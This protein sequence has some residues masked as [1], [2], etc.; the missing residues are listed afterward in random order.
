MATPDPVTIIGDHLRS[1]PEIEAMVG[2]RVQLTLEGTYP[3]IRL[4]LVTGDQAA[5]VA[6]PGEYDPEFQVECWADKEQ[7]AVTLARL[8]RD[9]LSDGSINGERSGAWVAGAAVTAEPFTAFDPTSSRPRYI[10][11]TTL[12]IFAL[13]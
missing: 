3:A 11:Q 7:D 4:T 12:V 13:E 8:V 9:A 10:V 2:D 5:T 1:R 6:E